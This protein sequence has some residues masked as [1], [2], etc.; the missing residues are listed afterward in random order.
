MKAPPAGELEDTLCDLRPCLADLPERPFE[1][2][3]LQGYERRTGF[4]VV[5]AVLRERPPRTRRRRTPASLAGPTSQTLGHSPLLA[6][7]VRGKCQCTISLHSWM[8]RA[9][10]ICKILLLYQCADL[11]CAAVRGPWTPLGRRR[12]R[13]SANLGQDNRCR[14]A[15]SPY[16]TFM[17]PCSIVQSPEVRSAGR[18]CHSIGPTQLLLFKMSVGDSDDF[19]WCSSTSTSRPQLSMP[20]RT[21][22]LDYLHCEIAQLRQLHPSS[23]HR[24]TR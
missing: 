11:H 14:S 3:R 21:S 15:A 12:F 16:R 1:I 13:P 5:D 22:T 24:L 19:N 8:I 7:F 10:R 4:L 20:H 6:L 17:A 9:Q 18:S 2:V 23:C